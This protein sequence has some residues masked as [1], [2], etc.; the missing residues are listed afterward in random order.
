[1]NKKG[2]WCLLL[3]L[4]VT[5]RLF[6][7]VTFEATVSKNELGINERLR[8]EFTMNTDGD[9]FQ[10]PSFDGFRVVAGPNQSVSNMFVNGKRSFSKSYTYFLT[11]LK[12]A[13]QIL[14]RRL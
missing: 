8:V 11:P 2:I 6:G 4:A 7:Q 3:V 14:V 5:S 13:P 10:P 9:N 12:R 1:M